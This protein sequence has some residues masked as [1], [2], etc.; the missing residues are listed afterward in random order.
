[1]DAILVWLKHGV[2]ALG[3]SAPAW[4]LVALALGPIVEWALGRFAPTKCASLIALIAT[5]LRAILTITRLGSIPI[6][7]TGIVRILET[8]A[9]VDLDGDGLIGDPPT[10]PAPPPRIAI[11]ALVGAVAFGSVGCAT[12]QPIVKDVVACAGPA[13][14]DLATKLLPAA[15]IVLECEI[16]T[17]GQSLPACAQQ[18]LAALAD[19]LGSDGWRIVGCIVNA[20]EKDTTK[21]PELRARAKAAR[22]IAARKTN[23]R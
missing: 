14:A 17:G 8:I 19:A 12:V 7:G 16:S 15:E 5:G 4:M 9:G 11:M 13:C 3:L 21:S 6:I 2:T 23:G 18:G 1:M 22:V 20:I 10:P